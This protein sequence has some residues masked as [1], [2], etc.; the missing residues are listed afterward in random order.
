MHLDAD[1]NTN[2]LPPRL[3]RAERQAQTRQALLDAAA[4]VFVER[5]F[6]ASSVEAITEQAGFTRGAFYSNFGSKE[7]LFAELLQQRVYDVY[8]G[9]AER[10]AAGDNPSLR[11]TGEQ[12]A[13]IQAEPQGQWL[14]RLWLELLAHAGRDEGFRAIA[15][16]FWSQ[17][18]A[19]TA[20]GI[21]R[22]YDEAGQELPAAPDHLA[23]ATIALDIGLALQH[24]VD[25]E[26]APLEL[27]PELYELLFEPLRPPREP[28]RR[29][30]PARS[31]TITRSR[32]GPTPT[33][34]IV[35]PTKLSM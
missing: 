32:A 31:L 4:Q 17:T 33:S 30:G 29:S 10:S 12:L 26:G 6:L 34:Q 28:A 5:G 13:R 20:L 1:V 19:M 21:K 25:P 3:T 23:T 24:F 9:M 7:E 18:R 27:Y 11:E 35:T 22:V 8:R 15:A 2:P 16:G 14:F